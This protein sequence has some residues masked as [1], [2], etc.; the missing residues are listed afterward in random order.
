MDDKQQLALAAWHESAHA[1]CGSSLGFVIAR[2]S[3]VPEIDRIGYCGV[4]NHPSSLARAIW[5]TAGPVGEAKYRNSI[6]M[7]LDYR[8]SESDFD[9]LWGV[10]RSLD[11][12]IAPRAELF[13]TPI[14]DTV[15]KDTEK[16]VDSLAEEID[17]FADILL[18]R[19][20]LVG[21]DLESALAGRP[22][23]TIEQ[24]RRELDRIASQM[25]RERRPGCANSP[26]RDNTAPP[27][28]G[29]IIGRAFCKD[30]LKRYDITLRSPAERQAIITE[31]RRLNALAN[32]ETVASAS[33]RPTLSRPT[34]DRKLAAVR[35]K[36]K[37]GHD[38]LNRRY[39]AGQ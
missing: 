26:T 12:D 20:T 8:G 37:R 25:K 21:R 9:D 7:E 1:V 28:F 32:G 19:K 2:V 15:W 6:G 31:N 27:L 29:K 35:A 4:E 23:K 30:I 13:D 22:I 33:T 18:Q 11:P 5:L 17:N 39:A 3:I 16:L 10:L 24:R 36:A 38:E 34:A 14:F